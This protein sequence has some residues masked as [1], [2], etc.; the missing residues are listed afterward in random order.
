METDVSVALDLKVVV[1]LFHGRSD[2]C[3][4]LTYKAL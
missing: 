2:V 4:K 1:H 3:S